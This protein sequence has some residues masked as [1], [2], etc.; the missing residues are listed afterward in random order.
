MCLL[1][2]LGLGLIIIGHL[3]VGVAVFCLP[4]AWWF[5]NNPRGN[6]VERSAYLRQMLRDL[7]LERFARRFIKPS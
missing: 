6:A 5:K 3:F 7:R 1:E 4:G 2:G